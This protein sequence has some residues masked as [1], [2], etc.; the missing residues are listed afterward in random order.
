MN[1]LTPPQRAAVAFIWTHNA[2]AA[3]MPLPLPV[4][5]PLGNLAL[6]FCAGSRAIH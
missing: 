1:G 6:L 5:T 3:V 4:P 2:P